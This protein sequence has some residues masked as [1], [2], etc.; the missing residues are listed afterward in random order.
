MWGSSSRFCL[1]HCLCTGSVHPRVAVLIIPDAQASF[2]HKKGG[3][4]GIIRRSLATSPWIKIMC[5]ADVEHVCHQYFLQSAGQH[6]ANAP[7]L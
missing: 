3:G 5:V 2:W 1:T 6:D 7:C 4:L